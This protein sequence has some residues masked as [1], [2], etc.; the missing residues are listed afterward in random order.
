MKKLILFF[1]LA[2]TTLYGQDASG[3]YR[4]EIKLNGLNLVL[5]NPEL[6]YEYLINS[7]SGAGLYA[8][9][10]ID[11]NHI[12]PFV[13]MAGAYYRL[14][15]GGKHA[16]GFFFEGGF[17]AIG[18]DDTEFGKN[19]VSSGWGPSFGIGGKFLIKKTIVME[20]FGGLGR[21]FKATDE[22]NNYDIPVFPRWGIS[23][24]KRF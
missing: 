12:W 7:N 19:K 4:H 18:F 17:N 9:A 6:D 5:G 11:R 23:I 15:L 16:N 2:S 8:N 20:F 1:L 14:Y 24:G 22:Y 13:Y 21:N 10:N 3:E